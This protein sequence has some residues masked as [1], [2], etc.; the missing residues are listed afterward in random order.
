MK[1]GKLTKEE[2][3]KLDEIC[4]QYNNG[5]PCGKCPIINNLHWCPKDIFA[6]VGNRIS[7]NNLKELRNLELR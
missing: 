1:F 3:N 6:F 7:E 4:K 5:E 2:L